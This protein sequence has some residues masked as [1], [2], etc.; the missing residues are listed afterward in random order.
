MARSTLS[1]SKKKKP[2]S[3]QIRGFKKVARE[4]ECED[5]EKAFDKA[6]G[7]IGKATPEP[8]PLQRKRKPLKLAI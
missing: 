7:Q 5:S 8:K 2:A 6:L 1:T 4:L 3:D